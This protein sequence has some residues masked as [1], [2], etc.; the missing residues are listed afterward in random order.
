MG[1]RKRERG[2]GRRESRQ[3][4]KK[5]MK[6]E[7]NEGHMPAQTLTEKRRYTEQQTNT[8]TH[9]ET[10]A[11]EDSVLLESFYPSEQRNTR[12]YIEL[13]ILQEHRAIA[14]DRKEQRRKKIRSRKRKKGRRPI[15]RS[16]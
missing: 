12:T 8:Q 10:R 15:R 4:C 14:Q 11:R 2:K 3:S 13:L 9:T 7:P 5:A 1:T 6:L 16:T